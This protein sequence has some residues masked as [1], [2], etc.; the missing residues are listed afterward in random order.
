[1][2]FSRALAGS[3]YVFLSTLFMLFLLLFIDVICLLFPMLFIDI[4]CVCYSSTLFVCYFSCYLS[5]LFVYV[6]HR[7]YLSVIPH[8][9]H[10]RYLSVIILRTGFELGSLSLD[11]GNHYVTR[12]SQ[13][14]YSYRLILISW[15]NFEDLSEIECRLYERERERDT[16]ID[17]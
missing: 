12:T 1:M 10:R 14:L 15:W 13:I 8:V 5:T 7:R 16:E 9:L 4:V 2:P 11:D 3:V 6:I 17:R